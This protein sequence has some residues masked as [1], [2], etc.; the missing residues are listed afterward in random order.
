MCGIAGIYHFGN[1]QAADRDLVQAMRD[2]L[3][4][5]GPDDCGLWVEGPVGLAQRRLAIVDLSEAGRNPMPNED[6][7]LELTFNGEVYNVLV[8]RA[9]FEARG[10]VMRS[11]TDSEMLL[12]L[13][14]EQGP[15]F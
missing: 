4:H 9:E 11:H 10:H 15:D 8:R 5:R 1:G 2:R 3:T 12:H 13:Y 7:S 6:G 14:E